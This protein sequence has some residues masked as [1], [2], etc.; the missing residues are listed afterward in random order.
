MRKTFTP[1]AAAAA[2]ELAGQLFGEIASL[3][4]RLD[5]E[6]YYAPFALYPSAGEVKDDVEK[7][8]LHVD[9]LREAICAIGLMA[10]RGSRATVGQSHQSNL[11][12]WLASPA[13]CEA[14]SKLAKHGDQRD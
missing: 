3:A 13:T 4:Q 12:D 5:R 11:A 2:I 8:E 7:L 14:A 6:C 9:R 1:D 10:D